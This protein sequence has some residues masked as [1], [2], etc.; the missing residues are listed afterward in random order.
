MNTHLSDLHVLMCNVYYPLTNVPSWFNKSTKELLT[1][2]HYKIVFFITD[3]DGWTD[4]F[5]A[6]MSLRLD[7]FNQQ[8]IIKA[9]IKPVFNIAQS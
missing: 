8:D 6:P 2:P 7:V 9:S 1:D 3:E 5:I 4:T